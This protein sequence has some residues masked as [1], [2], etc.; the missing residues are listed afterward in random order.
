MQN[1]KSAS[2]LP[3]FRKDKSVNVL[4]NVHEKPLYRAMTQHLAVYSD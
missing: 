4:Y 2:H 1:S 3:V